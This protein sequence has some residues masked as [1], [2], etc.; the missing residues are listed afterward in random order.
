MNPTQVLNEEKKRQSEILKKKKDDIEKGKVKSEEV[1][2]KLERIKV[3]YDKL[4]KLYYDKIET[5]NKVESILQVKL[6]KQEDERIIMNLGPPSDD[7]RSFVFVGT[8]IFNGSYTSPEI[9]KYKVSNQGRMIASLVLI[10]ENIVKLIDKK[11]LMKTSQVE[12][13]T[14]NVMNDKTL[15]DLKKQRKKRAMSSLSVEFRGLSYSFMVPDDDTY[16]F[17]DLKEDALTYFELPKKSFPLLINIIE[18]GKA[19]VVFMQN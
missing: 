17:K 15:K 1:K 18:P 16:T 10:S 5:I 19:K 7:I 6:K 12:L 14:F 4:E 11:N 2:G 3:K 9:E 13:T 8:R